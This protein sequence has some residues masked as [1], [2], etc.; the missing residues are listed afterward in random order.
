[1]EPGLSCRRTS[2]ALAAA[3]LMLLSADVRA[4]PGGGRSGPGIVFEG[5]EGPGRGQHLV[6]VAGD[7]EYRSEEAL[8]MLAK[9]LAV[10]HG[11]RCTVLFSVN[12]EDGTIDPAS[13]RLIPGLEAVAE[14]DMLV[15]FLRFRQLP[16]ADMRWLVQY[17]EAGRPLLGIRTAT[18]AFAYDKDSTSTYARWSWNSEEWPGGFG[19]QVLGETWVKHHGRHGSES[20]R[21]VIL[22]AQR[23]HPIL[24]GVG[25][26]WGPTDVYGIRNLPPDATV[27]VEGAVLSDMTPDGKPV[28]DGRNSPRMPLVWVRELQRENDLEAAQRIVCSTIGAS[29]DLNNEGLRR[30]LVNACY[31]G[32]GLEAEIPDR[33]KVEFVGEYRPL[34]FG[35]GGFQ[36]GVHPRDHALPSAAEEKGN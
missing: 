12:S 33:A 6:L 4:A 29:V 13:Q 20:T 26:L 16:D 24:R 28:E 2:G 17:V 25:D 5:G 10:H 32:T 36:K 11:F 1:M 9:I 19:R 8:P 35:F 7:E 34:P 3:L 21:G 15:L 31:W 14:A 30:L 23:S 27:L 18:H 22:E